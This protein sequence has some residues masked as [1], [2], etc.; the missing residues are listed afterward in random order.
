MVDVPGGRGRGDSEE[1]G[2]GNCSQDVIYERIGKKGGEKEKETRDLKQVLPWNKWEGFMRR[3]TLKNHNLLDQIV[4]VRSPDP[5]HF[6][7]FTVM[8]MMLRLDLD[9]ES[10]Y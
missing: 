6:P 8:R 4:G 1:R 3:V 2:R 9:G 10:S 5:T 7:P